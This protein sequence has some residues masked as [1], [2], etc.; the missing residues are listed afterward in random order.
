MPKTFKSYEEFE[1]E[2]KK[3]HT[4]GIPSIPEELAFASDCPKCNP[5][6][7][8]WKEECKKF[9]DLGKTEYRNGW[10]YK[11]SQPKQLTNYPDSK[12]HWGYMSLC[13]NCK[14]KAPKWVDIQH[15]ITDNYYPSDHC[16]I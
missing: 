15:P 10:W 6:W 8:Q 7:G 16:D 11:P 5:D 13:D 4:C 12:C 2:F 1:Q 9:W 14:P 3:Y